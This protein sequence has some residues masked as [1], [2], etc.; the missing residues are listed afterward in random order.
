MYKV[1]HVDEE[2]RNVAVQQEGEDCSPL[3]SSD[4]DT[5]N[6]SAR[7][8][9]AYQ[10]LDGAIRLMDQALDQLE[11]FRA[12]RS[13]RASSIPRSESLVSETINDGPS[14][15]TEED[16]RRFAELARRASLELSRRASSIN[17]T[18]GE[19]L[20][21]GAVAVLPA[22]EDDHTLSTSFPVNQVEVQD[23]GSIPEA[24]PIHNKLSHHHFSHKTVALIT[25]GAIALVLAIVLPTFL[26]FLKRQ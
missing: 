23:D 11:E 21:E 5:S 12:S 22:Y 1:L 4:G 7:I 16:F 8:G 9:R 19:D 14:I 20:E 10:Q 6:T 25:I 18:E 3:P 26:S 17:A 24:Q 13:R 2:T 15:A